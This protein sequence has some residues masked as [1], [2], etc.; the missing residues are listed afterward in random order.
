M[1]TAADWTV[2]QAEAH[3]VTGTRPDGT[4]FLARRLDTV[5]PGGWTCLVRPPGGVEPA[6]TMG[7]ARGEVGAAYGFATVAA[8][9][10]DILTPTWFHVP[11]RRPGTWICSALV[12]EALRCGGWY[13]RWPD[14]YQVTP[15]QLMSALLASGG[16]EI[17]VADA[18]PGDVGFAHGAG[19]LSGAIRF[20]QHLARESDWQ[21]NHAFLVDRRVE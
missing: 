11:L 8:T 6:R 14:I 17:E 15:A 3:G 10:V 16:R 18:Q 2:V 12:G 1:A 19:F 4:P 13:A 7:F 20:G 21:V 9:A 5:A